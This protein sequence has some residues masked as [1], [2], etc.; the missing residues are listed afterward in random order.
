MPDLVT[1]GETGLVVPAKP[2]PLA[3]AMRE[4]LG[5]AERRGRM[6]QAGRE[7]VRQFQAHAV[8]AR[9][10]AIYRELLAERVALAAE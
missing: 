4:L 7:K 10:E 8:V 9:I 5:D 3:A 6:G 1:D 2:A